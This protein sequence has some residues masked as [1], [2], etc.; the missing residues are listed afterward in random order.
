MRLGAVLIASAVAV[1]TVPGTHA[2]ARPKRPP[3][4]SYPNTVT[5]N[6]HVRVF[7][8]GFRRETIRRPA[9]F[10]AC[11]VRSR[12]LRILGAYEPDSGGTRLVRL[13]GRFVAFE[14]HTCFT[15]YCVHAIVR[16]NMRTGRRH[17]FDEPPI[18]QS[19]ADDALDLEVTARGNVV[20]IRAVTNP[21]APRFDVVRWDGTEVTVLD[22]GPLD[23]IQADSL[24]IS[25]RRAFWFASG[26]ARSAIVD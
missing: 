25:G 20:W 7:R 9:G 14:N 3:C 2:D 23:Q 26:Q 1:L 5:A 4:A 19:E 16:V 10:Y 24:A 15:I 8:I 17:A 11:D 13:A 22:S 18:G 21:A 12:R 6:A